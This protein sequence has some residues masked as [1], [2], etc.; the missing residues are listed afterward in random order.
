MKSKKNIAQG[1]DRLA[2]ATDMRQRLLAAA[3]GLFTQKGYAAT[4]V[5]EIVET[6]HTTAPSLYYYFRSKEGLYLEL[7]QTQFRRLEA[8]YEQDGNEAL[9][10]REQ[11]LL[12][13]D[14]FLNQ[15][16]EEKDAF[17]LMMAIFYGPPQGA[18]FIDFESYRLRFYQR[19]FE[20]IEKGIQAGELEPADAGGMAWII[21]GVMR[22]AIEEYV[23]GMKEGIGLAGLRKILAMVLD[24]LM[25]GKPS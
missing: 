9:S 19:L 23:I 21:I 4:S 2:G 5:R 17:R 15:I 24:R 18:P 3:L 10:F 12:L 20:L 1:K 16:V 11:I 8:L 13:C 6:A 14:A 22:V 25:A 7:M